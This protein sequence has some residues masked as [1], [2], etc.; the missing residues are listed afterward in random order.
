LKFVFRITVREPEENR[1]LGFCGHRQG[2]KNEMYLVATGFV[3]INWICMVLDSLCLQVL[4]NSGRY[5]AVFSLEPLVQDPRNEIMDLRCVN[6]FTL[7]P[8]PCSALPKA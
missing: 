1:M 2:N 7:L 4:V 5:C 8:L 6:L 3:D